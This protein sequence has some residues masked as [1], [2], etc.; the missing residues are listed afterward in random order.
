MPPRWA[1]SFRGVRGGEGSGTGVGVLLGLICGS[2]SVLRYR[3]IRRPIQYDFTP[4]VV[5]DIVPDIVRFHDRY[6]TIY[7][8]CTARYRTYTVPI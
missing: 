6:R 4:D 2:L 1:C 3:T 7:G 8:D 5:S